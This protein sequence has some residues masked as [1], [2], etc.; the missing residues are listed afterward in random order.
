LEGSNY[1]D[2]YGGQDPYDKSIKLLATTSKDKP[3]DSRPKEDNNAI[4]T[5]QSHTNNSSYSPYMTLAPTATAPYKS[6]AAI[7]S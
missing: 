4:S 1:Q 7:N 2:P 3:I 6:V 5:P